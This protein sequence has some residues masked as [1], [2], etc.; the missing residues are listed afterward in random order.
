MIPTPAEPIVVNLG[1]VLNRRPYV[2]I[3][4]MKLKKDTVNSVS[5]N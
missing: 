1:P 2:Y 5:K 3:I 4:I